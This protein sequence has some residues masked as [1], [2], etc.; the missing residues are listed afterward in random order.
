M[1]R[2]LK[3]VKL[4]FFFVSSLCHLAKDFFF[5]IKGRSGALRRGVRDDRVGWRTF[6]GIRHF[7]EPIQK[8]FRY[9]SWTIFDKKYKYSDF[10]INVLVN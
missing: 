4:T 1:L 5:E 8:S 10:V 9:F 3:G 7:N 2:S 6:R